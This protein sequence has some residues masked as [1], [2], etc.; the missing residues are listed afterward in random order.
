MNIFETGSSVGKEN[1]HT[2]TKDA[3]NISGGEKQKIAINRALVKKADL[4][5]LDEPSSSLDETSRE[6]LKSHLK[7]IKNK[8]IILIVNHDYS[9]LI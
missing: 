4:L 1:N 7:N 2:I 5:I 9:C 8:K 6:N 3:T